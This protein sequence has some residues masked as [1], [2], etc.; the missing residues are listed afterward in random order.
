[1]FKTLF[2]F[3]ALIMIFSAFLSAVSQLLLKLSANQTHKKVLN[4]YLNIKVLLGYGLILLTMFM[5]IYAYKGIDYK[6]GPILNTTTYIFV[7]ILSVVVLKEKLTKNKL[8]GIS[9]I[10]LG[11]LIFSL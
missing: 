1:M 11:L 2:N 3:F 7:V 9:L 6:L 5:N 4:E 8:I 10:I